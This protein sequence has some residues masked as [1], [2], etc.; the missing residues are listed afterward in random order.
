MNRQTQDKDHGRLLFAAASLVN[1][2]RTG[3]PARRRGIGFQPV[4]FA[5]F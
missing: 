3:I 5:M 4:K 2:Q 1:D